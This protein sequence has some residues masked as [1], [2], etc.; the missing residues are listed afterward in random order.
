MFD[1]SFAGDLPLIS[2]FLAVPDPER[3]PPR[4]DPEARQRQLLRSIKRLS[5]AESARE[6]GVTVIED[7]QWL[8]PASEVFLA[9]QVDAVQGTR[10][11]TVVNF[12]PEYHAVWMSRSYYRQ[13]GLVPLDPQVVERCLRSCSGTIPRWAVCGD[14]VRERTRGNPF[15]IEELVKALVEAGSLDGERGAYTLAAP[16]ADAAMPAR[17]RPCLQR[18]S[19]ASPRAT[20]RFCRRPR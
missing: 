2:D 9:S 8:D 16:A 13:I 19:I 14:L 3:L 18:G 7:L 4:M 20:S 1:D 10:S 15:F 17:C 5:R 6:P 11:V 12:R